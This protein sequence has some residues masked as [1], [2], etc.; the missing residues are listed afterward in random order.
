MWVVSLTHFQEKLHCFDTTH[1]LSAC[2]IAVEALLTSLTNAL[3]E[4]VSNW[5]ER[6][7][8]GMER[9]NSSTDGGRGSSCLQLLLVQIALKGIEG[10]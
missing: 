3:S 10:R 2:D 7:G 5:L 8:H 9:V 4:E 1:L 6:V